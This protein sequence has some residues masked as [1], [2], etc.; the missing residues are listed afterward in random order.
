MAS[1]AFNLG[2]VGAPTGAPTSAPMSTA[3]KSRNA[4]ASPEVLAGAF[5]G[6]LVIVLIVYAYRNSGPRSGFTVSGQANARIKAEARYQ[7]GAPVWSACHS[8]P[9]KAAGDHLCETL[10]CERRPP[11]RRCRAPPAPPCVEPALPP[12]VP[13][14]PCHRPDKARGE[15]RC[16]QS[17][18]RTSCWDPMAVEQAQGLAAASA[19]GF[20]HSG[21]ADETLQAVLFEGAN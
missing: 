11:R 14:N 9:D 5:A 10:S 1:S 18:C 7:A 16:D 6:V 3:T 2:D 20:D 13:H 8:R 4:W 12:I 21:I 17:V 19:T 15:A